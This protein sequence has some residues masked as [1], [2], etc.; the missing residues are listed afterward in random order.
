[1]DKDQISAIIRYVDA[2]IEYEL[3]AIG[4]N[5]EGEFSKYNEY[6]RT[7]RIEMEK[8]KEELIRAVE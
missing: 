5:D 2:R 1:M 3:S 4:T 6:G 8:A 7:E